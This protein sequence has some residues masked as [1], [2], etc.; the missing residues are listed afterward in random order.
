[1]SKRTIILVIVGALF[2]VSL[3]FVAP[4]AT[5]YFKGK[6]ISI[7]KE[8]TELFVKQKTSLE[9]LADQ[10]IKN[11][12]IDDKAAFMAV[13]EYKGLDENKIAGG[14]YIIKK[15]SS[16]KD[17]L[18]GFTKNNK[19]NGNAEVEV[20]VTFNNC[21]TIEDICG[22]VTQCIDIDSALLFK[23]IRNPENWK[24][25]SISMT[26][27]QLPALFI[28]NT[29]K[30]YYDTDAETFFHRMA[31][32]YK[33]FWS[34]E[35]MD[36]LTKIGLNKP[37]EATTIA[38]IVYAE[39]NLVS[40]EW[41]II[42]AVYLNRIGT[43]M[44]LQSCPTVR[45]CDPIGIPSQPYEKDIMRVKDCA[46]NTYTQKGMPP[47]PI[48][49]PS[50]KVVDAVLNRSAE[51]YLFMCAKPDNSHSHNFAVD[52]ATHSRNSALFNNYLNALKRAK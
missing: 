52:Y 37:Y 25:E 46:Y 17:L 49:I 10:L 7:N 20:Q 21:N 4:M 41:P 38:S 15:G 5:I 34:T 16:Y 48:N 11:N 51:K 29:Y 27:E 28:P 1:M 9:S 32:E 26:Y 19:G 40:Q 36:K 35:R 8:S 3:F 23:Y 31:E 47:G 30:M 50:P 2:L 6:K 45:Y 13:G 12:I 24:K 33:K 14:K 42:A 18:N 43:G 44:M 22:K 39:Q